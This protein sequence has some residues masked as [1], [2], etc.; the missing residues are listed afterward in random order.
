[1]K[2]NVLVTGAGSATARAITKA[3]RCMSLETR[4]VTA[5][6]VPL[7]AA[8]CGC[9][10]AYVTPDA[11]DAAY[12]GAIKRICIDEDIDLVL[13]G[14]ERE[15]LRLSLLSDDISRETGAVVLTAD[16]DTL[17]LGYDR[18]GT[19]QFLKAHGFDCPDTVLAADRNA[20]VRMLDRLGYPVVVKPRTGQKGEGFILAHDEETLEFAIRRPT[21]LIVQ[22]Y[23]EGDE[24]AV[25]VLVGRGGRIV[26]SMALRR[27]LWE[28]RIVGGE[29][30]DYPGIRAA[31]EKVA[32]AVK[33]LGPCNIEMKMTSRGP[34]VFALSVHFSQE[35]A[36]R[37]AFG[38]NEVE[39]AIRHY[40]KGED[41]VMP[42]LQKGSYSRYMDETVAPADSIAPANLRGAAE[43]IHMPT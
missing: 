4:I 10:A 8:H 11:S 17:M 40:L 34:V 39:W 12:A 23:L 43:R 26:G 19:V 42:P 9:D 38:F 32:A 21:G 41:F 28:G 18:W 22:E 24:Y 5:G 36:V 27:A 15:A 25:S 1:M 35:T 13:A 6:D 14:T 7:A 20:V 31:A 37:A 2:M 30:D 29:A 16:A 33:P 3:L